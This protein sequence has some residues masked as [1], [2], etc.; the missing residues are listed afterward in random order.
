MIAQFNR[1]RTH[2]HAHLLCVRNVFAPDIS[3]ALWN[4]VYH[5]FIYKH[6]VRA[7][8]KWVIIMRHLNSCVFFSFTLIPFL[9]LHLAFENASLQLSSPFALVLSVFFVAD[10]TTLILLHVKYVLFSSNRCFC[11]IIESQRDPTNCYWPLVIFCTI[12]THENTYPNLCN[13]LSR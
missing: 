5:C 4:D 7:T 13:Q 3:G 10:V 1:N 2:T 12:Y 6:L 11:I 9:S 8:N